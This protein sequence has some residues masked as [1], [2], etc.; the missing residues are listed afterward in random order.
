MDEPD[1]SIGVNEDFHVT[2]NATE[3]VVRSSA[4]LVATVD[5]P[6][7]EPPAIPMING[8][9]TLIQCYDAGVWNALCPIRQNSNR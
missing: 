8:F 4:T 5:L 2:M 3:V 9:S 7:P 1:V 6:D